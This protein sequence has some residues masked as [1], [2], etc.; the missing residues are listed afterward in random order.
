MTYE[1]MEPSMYLAPVLEQPVTLGHFLPPSHSE[2][3][4]D[5]GEGWAL[6]QQGNQSCSLVS[7]VRYLIPVHQQYDK[8]S[9]DKET[10]AWLLP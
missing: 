3:R 7:F 4:E 2:P 8:K 9:W 5:T 6:W 10:E 1:D